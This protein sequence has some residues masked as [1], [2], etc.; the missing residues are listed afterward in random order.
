MMARRLQLLG[1]GGG[2]ANRYVS[3]NLAGIGGYDVAA[4][5]AGQLYRERGLP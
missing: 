2:G 5:R 3:V 1:A 4:Q